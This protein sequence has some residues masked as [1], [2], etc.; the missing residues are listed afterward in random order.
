L[1]N[2]Y[3]VKTETDTISDGKIDTLSQGKLQR[4]IEERFLAYCRAVAGKY[5][6]SSGNIWY[7]GAAHF[8]DGW[9]L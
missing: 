4:T 6:R 8:F 1:T 5:H 7:F 3:P 2:S 9:P